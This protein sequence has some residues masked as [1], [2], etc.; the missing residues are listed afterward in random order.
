MID[1][2]SSKIMIELWRDGRLNNI[3]LA[4][5]LGISPFIV[6]K[7]KK[8]LIDNG[9][10]VMS[11]TA[12]PSK[13]GYMVG[14]YF[15]L[16]VEIKKIESVFAVLSNK[17]N[18]SLV[19]TCYGR[20]DI[21]IASY[22]SDSIALQKFVKTELQIINGI[23]H[24]ETY[25]IADPMKQH[26]DMN[27]KE[28]MWNKPVKLDETDKKIIKEL[29]ENKHATHNDIA[30]KLGMNQS[31]ISRRIAVLAEQGVI[32]FRALPSPIKWG[33]NGNALIL[34][35]AELAKVD[36]ICSELAGFPEVVL[37]IK[38]MNDFE[39]I[40]GIQAE[41]LEILHKFIKTKVAN[42]D[43]IIKIETSILGVLHNFKS[44]S[45]V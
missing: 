3:E 37:V 12:I 30:K 31:S 13:L 22:F 11:V 44:A 1:D 19:V 29:I 20:F 33:Y 43:G 27:I 18:V 34:M 39:I 4:K 38:L 45:P 9:D 10:L 6:A 41:D 28:S 26:W 40:F 42:I 25:L 32:Y 7:K 23:N 36:K 8:L 2:I 14:A 35:R 5:R 15:G 17:A 24:I 16:G 21:I